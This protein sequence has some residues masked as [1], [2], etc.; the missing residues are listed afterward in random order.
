MFNSIMASR[1]GM[2]SSQDKLDAISENLANVSTYGYKKVNVSFK[3]LLSEKVDRL[4]TPIYDKD[5]SNGTGVKTTNW[6][7]NDTQG[8][9]IDTELST[10]LSLEGEGYFKLTDTDGK[11]VYT[12]DGAFKVGENQELVDANGRRLQLNYLNGR[13]ASNVKFSDN[14]FNVDTNG[15]ISVLENG[16]YNVVANVPIYKGVSINSFNSIGDN[17]FVPANGAQITQSTNTLVHQKYLES[18]NVDVAKEMTD[19]IV[20]QRAFQLCSKAL[21]TSDEMWGMVNNMRK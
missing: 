11:D 2:N 7:R 18:S 14:N 16:V 13:N 5:S 9:L 12:R 4:G 15:N 21:T 19:M 3:D 1:S 8:P 20:T 6:F 10:D 17:L